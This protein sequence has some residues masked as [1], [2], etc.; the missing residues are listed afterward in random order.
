VATV[1]DIAETAAVADEWKA[2][3]WRLSVE[4]RASAQG[5][6]PGVKAASWIMLG[7][8]TSLAPQPSTYS[9]SPRDRLG[10]G[11][12]PPGSGLG[13]AQVSII[14]SDSDDISEAAAHGWDGTIAEVE[15]QTSPVPQPSTYSTSSRD[16]LGNG[17]RPPGSGLGLVQVSLRYY[18]F[19]LYDVWKCSRKNWTSMSV[20]SGYPSHSPAQ[21]RH[22]EQLQER[23]RCD[24]L[25]WQRRLIS[26]FVGSE[27]PGF[28]RRPGR[29]LSVQNAPGLAC[30]NISRSMCNISGATPA[31]APSICNI[32]GAAP[33]DERRDGCHQQADAHHAATAATGLR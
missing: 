19:H 22:A 17:L 23:S 18:G 20:F 3:H 32:S 4:G 11:L 1:E 33:S 21:G 2:A 28:Q 24:D 7:T 25:G 26:S 12:R 14:G 13:L 16:R 29:Q 27:G 8:Q 10:N 15:A 5:S 6:G 30:Q 31:V 9:T